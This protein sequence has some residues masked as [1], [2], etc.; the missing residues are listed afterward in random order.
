M[1]IELKESITKRET[2]KYTVDKEKLYYS[3]GYL[4]N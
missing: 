2:E 3:P 1:I 4:I